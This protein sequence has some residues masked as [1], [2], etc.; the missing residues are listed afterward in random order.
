[1]ILLRTC[2]SRA[3]RCFPRPGTEAHSDGRMVGCPSISRTLNR[4]E[5]SL[6]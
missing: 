2:G 4:R 1:L 5:E 6:C 3:V